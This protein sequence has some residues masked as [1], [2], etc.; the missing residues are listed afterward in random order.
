MALDINDTAIYTAVKAFAALVVP[1]NT[2][3]QRGQ[4]NRVPM[5]SVPCVVLTTLGT[6]KRIG[7]NL[8]ATEAVLVNG[9]IT[10]FTA[11]VT[12]DYEYRVQ[13]DFYSPDAES[14]AMAAEMLWRGTIGFNAMP[15]GMK[16]LYSE[17]RRQAP[18]IAAENQ[19]IQRWTMTL[20]LDYQPTWTQPTEAATS[21]TITPEPIEVFYPPSWS[22]DSASVTADSGSSTADGS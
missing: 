14:W 7:T 5:P 13:A 3:I 12:A 2:P 21:L 9:V 6:P 10:G 1:A 19:W 8:E 20:V 4:Q 22:A 18:I 15:A 16:P 11:A 17:D